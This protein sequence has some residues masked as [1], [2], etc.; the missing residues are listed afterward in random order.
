MARGGGGGGGF[1]GGGGGDGAAYND[2]SQPIQLA[3]C[4]N[5]GRK[6]A[7]DRLARHESACANVSKPRR[8]FDAA[9][10]RVAGTEAAAFVQKRGTRPQSGA[11]GGR[12]GAA[13]GSR[14]KGAAAAS[15]RAISGAAKKA[16]WRAEHEAFIANIRNARQVTQ[17]IKSGVDVRDLPPPPPSA[18]D[19]S[20]VPCPHCGRTFNETA[21]ERHIPRCKT[22]INRPK[23]LRR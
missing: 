6:F 11:R 7:R 21:A 10:M 16:K 23:A 20:L 1:G 9:K 15:E 13:G 5:C 19:P 4:G 17:A 3:Q 14:G 18:P 12:G 22:T 8:T 2:G